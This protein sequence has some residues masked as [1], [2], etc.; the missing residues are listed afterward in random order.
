MEDEIPYLNA[1]NPDRSSLDA[2][3]A[4]MARATDAHLKREFR[5]AARQ[6]ELS[7]WRIVIYKICKLREWASAS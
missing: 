4:Q 7:F 5:D 6:L 1:E 3:C 2:A